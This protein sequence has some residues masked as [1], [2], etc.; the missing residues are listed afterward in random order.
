MNRIP[1]LSAIIIA[2]NEGKRLE[3]CIK[4]L[5]WAD[6][7]IVVDNGSTDNTRAIGQRYK[8]IVISERMH[9]FSRL[10]NIGA[11]NA[12]GHW[13]LYVDADET[14]TSALRQEIVKIIS[15]PKALSAYV[16]PR[17]NWYLGEPWPF[18][19]GM[20]R[21]IQKD[22]FVTWEGVPRTTLT[23]IVIGG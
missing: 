6:E 2:K 23:V 3:E 11:R 20:I 8:A 17:K 14:I 4:N 5:L 18:Q 7:V 15:D 12:H 19:D 16:I 9:N 13:L 22:A 10:R 21:L 1:T